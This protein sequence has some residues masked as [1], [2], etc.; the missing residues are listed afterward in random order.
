M[1]AATRCAIPSALHAEGFCSHA[2]PP[3]FCATAEVN[4]FRCH[5]AHRSTLCLSRAWATSAAFRF[6]PVLTWMTARQTFGSL[7][8]RHC[9]SERESPSPPHS[10]SCRLGLFGS[11]LSWGILVVLLLL[12]YE[13]F[14]V[15]FSSDPNVSA[16]RETTTVVVGRLQAWLLLPPPR[17]IYVDI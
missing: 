8:S 14:V 1:R 12:A 4:P 16:A 2:R 9:S 10:L 13:A 7:D 17:W 5:R 11:F 6:R 3:W 15:C